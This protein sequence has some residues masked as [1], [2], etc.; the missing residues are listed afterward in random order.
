MASQVRMVGFSL[1]LRVLIR[2][3]VVVE[4]VLYFT[5]SVQVL[6]CLQI[7]EM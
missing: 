5:T 4:V 6:R 2:I 3:S 7:G 1:L